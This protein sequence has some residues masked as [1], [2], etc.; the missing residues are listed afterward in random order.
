[1]IIP[2]AVRRRKWDGRMESG[3][4]ASSGSYSARLEDGERIQTVRVS[5]IR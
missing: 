3:I 4:Q 5:L 1:M 2:H